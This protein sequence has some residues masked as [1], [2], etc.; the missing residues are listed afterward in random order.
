MW[1]TRTLISVIRISTKFARSPPS[2][3]FCQSANFNDGQWKPANLGMTF[4]CKALRAFWS[5]ISC[6]CIRLVFLVR[7]QRDD[8]RFRNN[9]SRFLNKRVSSFLFFFAQ[10]ALTRNAL[11]QMK[12]CLASRGNLAVRRRTHVSVSTFCFQAAI[13]CY[14][15]GGFFCFAFLFVVCGGLYRPRTS[16]FEKR[17]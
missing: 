1:W 9:E 13:A 6:F 8:K 10:N 11:V 7:T 12:C 2:Q 5:P 15:C 17:V 3:P 16:A 4:K 14:F